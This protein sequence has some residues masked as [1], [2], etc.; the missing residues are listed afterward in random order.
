MKHCILVKWNLQIPE[1][2][3]VIADIQQ[4]FQPAL[5]QPGIHSIEFLPNVVDLANRYDLM[6]VMT[7]EPD[8]LS[9]F[10]RSAVHREWKEKYGKY[11]E[12][13]AVFDCDDWI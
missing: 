5:S 4:I 11:V 13:K 12:S 7:M 3:T 2:D 1:K 9:P 6:I 10:D 8:A